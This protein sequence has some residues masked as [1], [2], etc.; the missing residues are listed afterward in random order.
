MKAGRKSRPPNNANFE[1]KFC[2]A[3]WLIAPQTFLPPF[4]GE[5]PRACAGKGGIRQRRANKICAKRDAAHFLD[6]NMGR[7]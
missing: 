4:T 6:A 7:S 3:I 2:Q 1:H 5:V